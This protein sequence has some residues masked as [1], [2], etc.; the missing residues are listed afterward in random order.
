MTISVR[1]AIA[2]LLMS[3]ATDAG[4][5]MQAADAGGSSASLAIDRRDGDQYGWAI[6]YAT[7]EEAD[8]RALAECEENGDGECRVVLRFTG[9]CGAYAVER[10]NSSL[11]GWGTANSEDAAKRRALAEARERG[12]EDVLVRVWGCN[13]GELV[14]ADAA[15]M[16]TLK[17]VYLFYF[18]YAEDENRCFITDVMF[19][20]GLAR[21]SGDRWVWSDD[22]KRK[23]MPAAK[24]YLGE[25]EDNLYGY[26]GDLKDEAIAGRNYDWAGKN[27]VDGN[28]ASLDKDDAL[29]RRS[30]ELAVEGQKRLCREEGAEVVVIDVDDKLPAGAPSTSRASSSGESS[31]ERRERIAAERERERREAEAERKRELAEAAARLEAF[32]KEVAE[33]QAAVEAEHER[34]QRA[35]EARLREVEA[36]KAQ[37]ARDKAA[38][39]AAVRRAEAARAE[40]ER[41]MEEYRQ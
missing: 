17:G 36:A 33:H 5:A 15:A 38:H 34:K 39:E 23:L 6:D 7:R 31:V 12:G 24:A 27:E 19:A 8:A 30:L 2:T 41:R 29:R 35:Y 20:P 9:G 4:A 37:Y 14:S 18:D 32:K 26:L 1:V 11:Y 16:D 21:R 10:G 3:V 22:A 40:Y 25:V 13:G 28:N